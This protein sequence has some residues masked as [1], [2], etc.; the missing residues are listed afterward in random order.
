MN[1][2]KSFF[3][4]FLLMIFSTLSTMFIS[5]GVVGQS[6][7]FD[8]TDISLDKKYPPRDSLVTI[9]TWVIDDAQRKLWDGTTNW[10]DSFAV[11]NQV[12]TFSVIAWVALH[13]DTSSATGVMSPDKLRAST[14]RGW[15]CQ[16]HGY[17]PAFDQSGPSWQPN[18]WRASGT[19][20]TIR[21]MHRGEVNYQDYLRDAQR[22][23]AAFDTLQLPPPRGWSSPNYS[24]TN[25]YKRALATVGY[26][27]GFQPEGNATGETGGGT[28]YRY[29]FLSEVYFACQIKIRGIAAYPNVLPPRYEIQQS[30]SEDDSEAEIRQAIWDGVANKGSWITFIMHSPQAFETANPGENFEDILAFVDSMQ[31]IGLIRVMTAKDAYDL[32]WNTPIS[33]AA[34]FVYPNFPDYNSDGIL[35]MMDQTRDRVDFGNGLNNYSTPGTR[36]SVFHNLNCTAKNHG[37][38]GQ[39]YTVMY[40]GPSATWSNWNGSSAPH[41]YWWENADIRYELPNAFR[42]KTIVCEF[43]AQIDP[44]IEDVSGTPL[45]GAD[46]IGVVF[47]ASAE[48]N[49]NYRGVTSARF[50]DV[51]TND[52]SSS[53]L[54]KEAWISFSSWATTYYGNF[55]TFEPAD[56]VGGDWQHVYGTWRVPEDTDYVYICPIKDSRFDAGSVRISNFS[57]SLAERNQGNW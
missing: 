23:Y 29:N 36:D 26:E 14:A 50:Q 16:G 54:Q 5:T 2:L 24:T 37:V 9:L 1:K 45:S 32:F 41:A 35:D 27:F 3:A 39:G 30:I 7:I 48:K 55:Q 19:P 8:Q 38:M 46:S 40:N 11:Y 25:I 51:V 21:A 20:D 22:C 33:E 28:Q 4:L 53:A 10:V 13:G 34:N 42:G 57:I 56:T 47:Y 52:F 15:D 12:G 43:W 6:M 17:A 18:I 31:T 44:A 49:W